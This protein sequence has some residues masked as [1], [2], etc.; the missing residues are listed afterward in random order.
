MNYSVLKN[1][2]KRS[3]FRRQMEERSEKWFRN[4]TKNPKHL[5]AN[6]LRG[7][8][9]DYFVTPTLKGFRKHNSICQT[10]DKQ[11]LTRD[12]VERVVGHFR[13]ILKKK[14][15]G[16]GPFRINFVAII[17]METDHPNVHILMGEPDQNSNFKGNVPFEVLIRECWNKIK[18][19]GKIIDVKRI[20]E[21][22]DL[23][24]CLLSSEETVFYY[25]MK[26]IKAWN[27]NLDNVCFLS[28]NL[29]E[30]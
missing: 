25:M 23:D 29:V 2:E 10:M 3:F 9:F 16:R 21:D 24:G 15:Y 17:H 22:E 14:L 12:Q 27:G 28:M 6:M 1:P 18:I 11:D 5:L 19:A 8:K 20:W 26:E 30:N 13:N 4:Y 7:K